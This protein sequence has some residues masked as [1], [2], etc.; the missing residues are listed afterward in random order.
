MEMQLL[1]FFFLTMLET[2]GTEKHSE[3]AKKESGILTFT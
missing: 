2:H 3:N 1:D